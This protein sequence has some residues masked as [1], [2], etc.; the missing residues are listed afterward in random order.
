MLLSFPNLHPELWPGTPVKG[1]KFFDPGLAA[2]PFETGFRPDGLPLDPKTA[3]A[4]I[5]DC[6]NF[7]RQFKNPSE[8]AWFGAQT[9]DD[10][11]EGSSMSIQSQ[12]TRT[13]DDGMGTKAERE[14][15]DA[16]AKAQFV[17]LL[18]W[19]F[20]ERM[21]ELDGLEKGVKNAWKGM[22]QTLGVDEDD[23]LNDRVVSL[24]S[25]ESHTGGASDGQAI[26]FPW[27]RVVEALPGF[28]PEGTVL[29]CADPE[30]V[31]AWEEQG[32]EFNDAHD[33]LKAATCPAWKF[34]CR[35]RAPEGMPL[36]LKDVTVAVIK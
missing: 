11:Y 28:I 20:E 29:V 21:L 3:A 16:R 7:G 26:P 30:I 19:F 35:R 31:A 2:E 33:G 1:L 5:N 9:A 13:F 18:A 12:L 15:K 8:M 22:D 27:K 24:G 32:I 10:F 25:A 6:I 34:A 4:L 23:R 36:A 17:L 14:M